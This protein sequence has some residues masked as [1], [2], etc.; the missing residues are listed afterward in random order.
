M[1]NVPSFEEVP[2]YLASLS[3]QIA[4]I[5]KDIAVLTR[6]ISLESSNQET[7]VFIGIDE[8]CALVHLAK[9]TIYKLAQK[10]LIPHYKPSKELLFRKTELIKWVEDSHRIGKISLEEMAKAM[11]AGNR[12]KPRRWD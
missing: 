4:Q 10:R 6:N 2:Q 7:E 11:T 9:P 12:R 3:V 8:A 1:N 5:S